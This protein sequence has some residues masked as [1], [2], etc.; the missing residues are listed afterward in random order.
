MA[1]V[2]F[3]VREGEVL[4]VVG[5]SGSGK[6]TLVRCLLGLISPTAG[7]IEFAGVNITA[8]A[9]PERRRSRRDL[10]VVFQDPVGSLDPRL[11]VR[12][13]VAEPLQTHEPGIAIDEARILSLLE[14]VGLARIHLKR[15][16][17][18]LSG[19]Q[20]QRVA[21]ARAL[22]LRP[23]LVVLDE[24]TSS[25]DVSVQAQILNLLSDLRQRHG[26]SYILVSH[27]LSVVRHLTDRVAVMYLGRIVEE[28][29]TD[30][31][32][33]ASRHPY[34]R[35]LLAAAPSVERGAGAVLARGDPPR[36]GAVEAGCPFRSRCWLR[37]QLGQPEICDRSAPPLVE[38]PEG[39]RAACH[40]SD[41]VMDPVQEVKS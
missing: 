10:Q 9:G 20:C 6:T 28:A 27:D 4:G 16:A 5:E 29:T 35:A 18:E 32:F 24:P 14:E 11:S 7:R 22:A 2:A 36:E 21:I 33:A 39:H 26:L 1:D 15:R 25:L 38:A 41:H 12:D 17:H 19:G 13:L 40:F 3:E 31:L 30:D 23:R 34:A 8:P 37:E